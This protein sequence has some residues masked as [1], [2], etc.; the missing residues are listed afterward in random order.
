MK[1]KIEVEGIPHSE[2]CAQTGST[3]YDSNALQKV[4]I[5][6]FKNQIRRTLKVP[7][8]LKMSLHSNNHDFG[9]YYD[10]QFTFDEDKE[11]CWEFI[12]LV[13]EIDF[14]DEISLEELKEKNYPFDLINEDEE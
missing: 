12:N 7:K 10:L 2:P 8:D 13:E 1:V 9:V 3:I 6:V 14:W 4:E 5:S 11:E